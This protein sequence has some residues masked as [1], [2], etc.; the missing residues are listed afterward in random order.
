MFHGTRLL[1]RNIPP[2]TEIRLLPKDTSVASAEY[3]IRAWPHNFYAAVRGWIGARWRPK[4][5]FA[6]RTPRGV[7]PHQGSALITPSGSIFCAI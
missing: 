2:I 6:Q 7:D 4:P 1:G 3:N 5:S